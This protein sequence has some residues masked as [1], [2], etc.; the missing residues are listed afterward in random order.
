MDWRPIKNAPYQTV[1]WVRNAQMEKPI[2]AT[3]GYADDRG[4]HSDRSFFTSVYTPDNFFPQPAGRLVCP[5][6]WAEVTPKETDHAE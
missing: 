2:L 3:R 4:V 5:S 6:E 1:V